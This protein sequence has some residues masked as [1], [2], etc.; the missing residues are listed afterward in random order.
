MML[1][2]LPKTP[3]FEDPIAITDEA[4]VVCFPA[5]YFMIFFFN[6]LEELLL[7]DGKTIVAVP[8]KVFSATVAARPYG[9]AIIE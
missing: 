7:L 1:E 8:P 2:E 4:T 6:R 9:K 3:A 5:L